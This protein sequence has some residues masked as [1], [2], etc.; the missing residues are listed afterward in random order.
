MKLNLAPIHRS[1]RL[2]PLHVS[3][4]SGSCGTTPPACGMDETNSGRMSRSTRLTSTQEPKTSRRSVAPNAKVSGQFEMS[5]KPW[6]SSK[7]TR[8][9]LI[10]H[11]FF[12]STSPVGTY[13]R[14]VSPMNVVVAGRVCMSSDCVEDDGLVVCVVWLVVVAVVPGVRV[15]DVCEPDVC[16]PDVWLPDVCVPDVDCAAALAAT[17]S[18]SVAA[19]TT[20]FNIRTS[21]SVT[22]LPG[23]ARPAARDAKITRVALLYSPTA[24]ARVLAESVIGGSTR[25]PRPPRLIWPP[26]R[27][28]LRA[29]SE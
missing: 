13:H 11:F 17:A 22:D 20:R 6:L 16:V 25:R 14:P 26:L 27:P 12:G 29:S 5:L 24:S 1:P 8:Y 10:D 21:A 19:I 15:P 18:A 7:L 3:A 9:A 23:C 28:A 2:L 4:I